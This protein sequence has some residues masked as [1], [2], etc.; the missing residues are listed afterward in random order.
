M[1]SHYEAN[2]HTGATNVQYTC[3]G[4]TLD[5]CFGAL[6]VYGFH[7]TL[8]QKFVLCTSCT[9]LGGPILHALQ[10]KFLL[11][12]SFLGI[13]RPQSQFPHSCVCERFV[14]SQDRST[15]FLQKNRQIEGGN[16]SKFAHSHMNVAVL[17][18]FWE[19][20]FPI[21][22]I[23]SLQCVFAVHGSHQTDSRPYYV[24]IIRGFNLSLRPGTPNINVLGLSHETLAR[25][26]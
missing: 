18:L 25:V 7:Q 8:G 23:G 1:S 13:A 22:G 16:I 10:R 20:L 11:C 26:S 6:S 19:Y 21:F 14:Y 12:I 2:V 4:A 3:L 15:Y 9:V 24:H 17:F 5:T